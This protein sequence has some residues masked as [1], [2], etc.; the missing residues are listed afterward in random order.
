MKSIMILQLAS[1]G[2]FALSANAG[3]IPIDH[4][5]EIRQISGLA[6]VKSHGPGAPSGWESTGFDDSAWDAAH[7][8]PA[9]LSPIYPI[10]FEDPA[11]YWQATYIWH[12]PTAGVRQLIS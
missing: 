12:D 11:N 4:P 1:L 2:I 9:P 10:P 5:F 3:P 7:I 6:P 8:Y